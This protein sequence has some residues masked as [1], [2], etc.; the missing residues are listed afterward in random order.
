MARSLD[1][2]ALLRLVD[3]LAPG[4]WV[5]GAVLA[6][7]SG[8]SRAALSNR[9][10]RL[11]DWYLEVETRPGLGYRLKR[12]LRRLDAGAIR[13]GLPA[14]WRE[15]LTLQVVPCVDSTNARLL[16]APQSGDP[17]ALLAE[18]QTSGRG[19]RGRAWRSPFGANLYLSL[20]WSFAAWPPR[21]TSLSL[22]AGVC[23]ARALRR[24]GLEG[25]AL[26]WPND[27][28]LN[29]AK[30]GGI[31]IEQR[32]EAGGA[33]RV[34]IGFGLNVSMSEVQAGMLDQAWTTVAEGMQAANRQP[35]ARNELAAAVLEELLIGLEAFTRNGFDPFV[36]EWNALDLTHGC[37]VKV[38][39]QDDAL[40]GTARG[41]NADGAL[42]VENAQGMHAV[43]A[44]DVSLRFA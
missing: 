20:A 14:A 16:D 23:C 9:I 32:G 3:A 43:H 34:V 12:P 10:R 4:E 28:W 26:K 38:S 40:A 41:V 18:L 11:A 2:T 21:L 36:A 8:I 24:M 15:R 1:E 44:G 30:L 33:C 31:L 6:E 39:G 42:L 25:V 27:L 37:Q 19:R 22:A 13:A 17:Q 35:P 29:R 7:A 5:S